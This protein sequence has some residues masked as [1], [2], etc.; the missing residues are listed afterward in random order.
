MLGVNPLTQVGLS[1][2]EIVVIEGQNFWNSKYSYPFLCN[3][4]SNVTVLF[5]YTPAV[6][7]YSTDTSLVCVAPEQAEYGSYLISVSIGQ[8]MEC[9]RI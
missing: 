7:V 2:G 3:M 6:C 8:V 4:D 1:S 5:G 9:M